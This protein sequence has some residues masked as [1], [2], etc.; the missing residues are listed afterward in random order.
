MCLFGA[1]R[2]SRVLGEL[3]ILYWMAGLVI[4]RA[5]FPMLAAAAQARPL[6]TDLP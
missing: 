5:L 3:T 6:E 2:E 1:M 4:V